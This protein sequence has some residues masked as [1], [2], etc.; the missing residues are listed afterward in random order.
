MRLTR[1][2]NLAVRMLL[3]CA[4]NDAP[5]SQVA[6]IADAYSVSPLHLAQ[7]M[8]P[9]VD[10]GMLVTVRGRGG[11]IRLGR[12]ADGITLRDVVQVTETGMTGRM[13]EPAND[14]DNAERALQAAFDAFLGALEHYTIADLAKGM[15]ALHGLLRV[16]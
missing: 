7:I 4:V 3:Y 12:S 9:L 15:P 8:K 14:E 1:Q 2:T 16:A 10:A 5:L 6:R 11:G 13:D